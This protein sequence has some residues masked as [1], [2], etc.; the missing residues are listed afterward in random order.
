LPWSG[1]KRKVH[2]LLG[3]QLTGFPRISGGGQ[4]TVSSFTV[5]VRPVTLR[6]FSLKGMANGHA[7][8]RGSRPQP[9]LLCH[10]VSGSTVVG[11][12]RHL[13]HSTFTV[14]VRPV[15][16]RQFSLKGM[17]NGHALGGGELLAHLVFVELGLEHVLDGDKPT[18]DGGV[19]QQLASLQ[20]AAA[21]NQLAL[22]F[23]QCSETA[24]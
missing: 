10:K 7:F 5:L 19:P 16:L 12:L 23:T 6:Q 13:M 21:K 15:A 9:N 3:H 2:N 11:G 8:V 24:P 20:T 4:M 1:N 18:W 14:L 22:V 17:A